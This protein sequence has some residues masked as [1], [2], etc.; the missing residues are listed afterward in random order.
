[1]SHNDQER[2]LL[3]S[4]GLKVTPQRLAVL[5]AL[6]SLH[7]HPSADQV[8]EIVRN[9]N[10]DIA[11]GTI[12]KILETFVSHG[13][14]SKVKTAG[15]IMRYDAIKVHHHHLYCEHSERIE[16]FY[17]DE[18]SDLIMNYLENKQIPNFVIKDVKLQIIGEFTNENH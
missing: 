4:K 9:H 7:N 11:T 5:Q 10:P 1:M 16:D 17:N 3:K 15:D 12:Y 2:E 6:R 18:L 13:I 14:I 8:S